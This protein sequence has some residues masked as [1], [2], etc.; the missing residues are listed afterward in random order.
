MQH[1][2]YCH[3]KCRHPGRCKTTFITEINAF[4]NK[5][6]NFIGRK[7]VKLDCKANIPPGEL[8]MKAVTAAQ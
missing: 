4:H 8:V 7:Q 5:F 6:Y 2:A 1:C 3:E